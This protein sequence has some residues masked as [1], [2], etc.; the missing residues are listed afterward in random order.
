MEI[1]HLKGKG[2]SPKVGLIPKGDRQV[3]LL[4]GFGLFPQHDA[5]ERR[6]GWPDTRPV[7]TH[8]IE[9]LDVHDIEAA[10][11]IHQHL[12]E[13]LFVDDRIDDK[14]VSARM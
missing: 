4:E 3:D 2:H 13:A 5:V 12:A 1:D 10:S 6:F 8:G 14:W 7:D 11:P 9:R